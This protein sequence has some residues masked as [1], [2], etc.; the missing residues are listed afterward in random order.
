MISGYYFTPILYKFATFKKKL[1]AKLYNLRQVLNH[2][3]MLSGSI[4]FVLLGLGQ[5]ISAQGQFGPAS[6]GPPLGLG[7]SWAK[8]VYR[9]GPIWAGPGQAQTHPY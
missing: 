5:K 1:F 6:F 4:F 7:Q 8:L 9:P 2:F 3:E